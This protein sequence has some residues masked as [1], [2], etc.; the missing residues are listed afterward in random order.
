MRL[1]AGSCLPH[2]AQVEVFFN[3]YLTE[4]TATPTYPLLVDRRGDQP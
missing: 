1:R 3:L 4:A 2:H